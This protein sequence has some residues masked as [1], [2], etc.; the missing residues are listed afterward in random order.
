M[1]SRCKSGQRR[2]QATFV[3]ARRRLGR[4]G[5]CSAGSSPLW[6]GAT[7]QSAASKRSLPRRQ[8][9]PR[10]GPTGSR[11]RGKRAKAMEGVKNLDQQPQGALRRRGR[12]MVRQ[13]SWEQERPV[14]A[15]AVRPD[16]TASPWDELGA[17]NPISGV[18]DEMGESG[19]GVGGGHSSD[20]GV[21]N[22][23]RW[24]EGPLAECAAQR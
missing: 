5:R 6:E 16:G 12:G 23:T 14:S 4:P 21:D 17:P 13:P 22:R 18:P 10:K 15:P 19:A 8:T 3:A 7:H 24:S 9:F 2:D 11:A 1:T 20:E